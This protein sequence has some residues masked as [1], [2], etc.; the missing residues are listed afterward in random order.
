MMIR[1]IFLLYFLIIFLICSVLGCESVYYEL[2]PLPKY[3]GKTI[4]FPKDKFSTDNDLDYIEIQANSIMLSLFKEPSML[5]LSKDTE[6]EIYRFLLLDGNNHKPLC[7]RIEIKRSK[8]SLLYLKILQEQYKGDYLIGK[9]ICDSVIDI[10]EKEIQK[11]KTQLSKVNF[12]KVKPDDFPGYIIK[13]DGS[14]VASS[15]GAKWVFEGIKN[16]KYQIF[17]VSDPALSYQNIDQIIELKK[18]FINLAKIDMETV[19]KDS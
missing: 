2:D 3:T 1:S 7:V 17:I 6:R 5:G 10:T 14:M 12:W 18:I 9:I 15:G 16:G 13:E 8:K 11:F 4:Y 19:K